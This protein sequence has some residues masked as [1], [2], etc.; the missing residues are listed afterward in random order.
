[1]SQ[2]LP[3]SPPKIYRHISQADHP[4][5]T[6]DIVNAIRQDFGLPTPLVPDL[7]PQFVTVVDVDRK[8]VQ[9]SDSFC[10]LVGYV[11]EDLLGKPYDFLTAPNTLDISIS[12]SLFSRLGY[13]HGLWML[14]SQQGTRI[15]VR[16]ESWLRPDAFIEGHMQLLGTGY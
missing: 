14:V 9:V 7:V 4:A 11:R 15:L 12:F 1:M 5:W 3:Y 13:M 16:Y 6:K 2:K 10:K 8:Y